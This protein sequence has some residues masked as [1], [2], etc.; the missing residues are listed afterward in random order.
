MSAPVNKALFRVVGNS[1]SPSSDRGYNAVAAESLTL[2]LESTTDVLSVLWET[3]DPASPDSPLSSFSAPSFPFVASGTPAL[4]RSAPASFDAA[5]VVP[6]VST[7]VSNSWHVRCTASTAGGNFVFTRAINCKATKTRKPIPGESTEN[8]ANGWADDFAALVETAGATST[9]TTAS[10]TQPAALSNVTVAVG[11]TSWM[12]GGLTVLVTG[13]GYYTVVS[14]T[15]STHVLLQNTGASGNAAPTTTVTS[16]ARVVTGGTP[17]AAGAA[18]TNGTGRSAVRAVQT[19]PLTSWVYN[20]GTKTLT[21][22]SNGLLSGTLFD[23]VTLAFSDSNKRLLV[24]SATINTNARAPAATINGIYDWTTAGDAGTKAVLTRSSDLNSSASFVGGVVVDIVDGASV[25]RGNQR[26]RWAMTTVGA[27]TLDTTPIQFVRVDDNRLVFDS[28]ES[29]YF[30]VADG[31]TD[32][33]PAM[34]QMAKDAFSSGFVT[35]GIQCDYSLPAGVIKVS[36]P[37]SMG[38]GVGFHC[39]FPDGAVLQRM[40]NVSGPLFVAGSTLA[41]SFYGGTID[42]AANATPLYLYDTGTPN[43]VNGPWFDITYCGGLYFR[44]PTVAGAEDDGWPIFEI[45]YNLHVVALPDGSFPSNT[46]ITSIRGRRNNGDT[47]DTMLGVNANAAGNLLTTVRLKDRSSGVYGALVTTGFGSATAS[48]DATFTPTNDRAVQFR[49]T[50]GGTVGTPGI[51]F[52]YSLDGGN[53]WLPDVPTALG[54]ATSYTISEPPTPLA[55]PN[56][57]GIDCLL[58]ATGNVAS[59]SGEQT[60]DGTLTSASIVLLPFQSTPSQNG[61]WL[62]GAGAWTRPVGFSVD[63]DV[64]VGKDFYV[65]SGATLG[66]TDWQLYSGSTIAGTKLF[67][68]SGPHFSAKFNLSGTIPANA[69]FTCTTSGVYAGYTVTN[70]TAL[71]N[72]GDYEITLQYD[73]T[74]ITQ[75]CSPLGGARVAPTIVSAHGKFY[76]KPWENF[77][78]GH[79]ANSGYE[80]SAS[81]TL[82]LRFA[83]GCIRVCDGNLSAPPSTTRTTIPTNV[84]NQRF[85]WLPQSTAGNVFHD[86][87]GN[88]IWVSQNTRNSGT[89]GVM[90]PRRYGGV[91]FPN[92]MSLRNIKFDGNTSATSGLL[93]LQAIDSFFDHLTFSGGNDGLRIG[94]PSFFN[95]WG[96]MTFAACKRKSFVASNSVSVQAHGEWKFEG[97][98]SHLGWGG[99][100]AFQ[101]VGTIFSNTEDETRCPILTDLSLISD[102]PNIILD[103]ENCLGSPR[104]SENA[105]VNIFANQ[106]VRFGGQIGSGLAV[107]PLTLVGASTTARFV[108]DKLYLPASGCSTFNV[109]NAAAPPIECGASF[110]S[111]S[112]S[113]VNR[114]GKARLYGGALPKGTDLA[115]GTPQTLSYANGNRYLPPTTITADTTFN[116]ADNQ[117]L[118][119]TVWAFFLGKQ[120][121]DVIFTN[122]G[123]AGGSYTFAAGFS[124]YVRFV[125][126]GLFNWGI[127]V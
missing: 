124:G 47:L 67:Y 13:G 123:P 10:F 78:I 29:P 111:T 52:Q 116:L 89:Y 59:L 30:V 57:Y 109:L 18:G 15:D 7:P 100:S 97:G 105:R 33:Y 120:T 83:F 42:T 90:W 115:D 92:N 106:V 86:H 21:A 127:S 53:S 44:T 96:S 101:H 126:D 87:L 55:T 80:D 94:G 61:P 73:G 28:T 75:W 76:Q 99:N 4:L 98:M 66:N 112:R 14:V 54:S 27:I 68:R 104:P 48:G 118:G 34:L 11:D 36:F 25:I 102:V 50:T 23:N 5:M 88:P 110:S 60:I 20:A 122:L 35:A 121:H 74:N 95:E 84:V 62:T 70:A 16:P 117:E 71:A 125:K 1:T 9:S 72:G 103:D 69:S 114:E 56:G 3:Y 24:T 107:T 51:K 85:A 31:A 65:T 113:L 93:V 37:P 45:V 19:S 17:G 91:A 82:P 64:V 39:D 77:V 12:A 32:F 81:D 41:V 6:T 8:S 40:Q 63:A 38:K 58:A 2:Q 46:H 22:P 79:P 49:F 108:C 26:S 119:S 43:G